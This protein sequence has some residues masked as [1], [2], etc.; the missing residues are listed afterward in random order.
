MT[1]CYRPC[2]YGMLGKL[3]NCKCLNGAT[4]QVTG[5]DTKGCLC[6]NGKPPED[7]GGGYDCPDWK[8]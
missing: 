5:P 1:A 4:L 8:P 6:P 7:I 3:P 2:G